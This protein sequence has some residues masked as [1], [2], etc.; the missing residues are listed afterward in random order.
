MQ[1]LTLS[2]IILQNLKRKPY[3]TLAV[4]LFVLIA[5][6]SLFAATL[7]L[8]GVQTSLEVGVARMG[9]DLIVVPRGQDV[10]AQEAFI[11]GQPT[12]F[13]MED[14]AQREIAALP[15]VL[16]ASPQV[17][18][19]SLANA[20]C[21]V[22]EFFLVSF[23]PRSDFT[24]A[25][26]LTTHLGREVRADE[27]IVGDRILLRPGETAIFFGTPFKV[28]GTLEP[29]GMGI[30]RTVFV[31]IEG[32]RRM[33]ADSSVLAEESLTISPTQISTVLVKVQSGVN[34]HD[35]AEAVENRLSRAQAI[36]T[37]QMIASVG[38]QM[39]S[40]LTIIL[41][42]IAALWLM[43]LVAIGLVFTLIVNERQR[44]L[45][46]LRAMG[47]RSDFVF[48]LMLGEATLLTGTGGAIGVV[49]SAILVISFQGLLEQRLKIPFLF[50]TLPEMLAL[51]AGLIV[52]ALLS[53][54]LA[55]FQ[56]AFRISR[57]EPYLAIRLGE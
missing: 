54:A 42:A 2:Y 51:S 28:V 24:I 8:R 3:R 10:S 11:V 47:A 36:T 55:C 7:L 41:A 50:P 33:I 48:R 22:G 56:P 19:K 4:A 21:C 40:L 30:D 38:R 49:I 57:M 46:L 14:Q 52:L 5:T 53:G 35:V 9:A 20:S 44:E 25:P 45:G 15:G 27:I 39:T 6:G 17:F 37:S 29:T 34:P 32:L 13:Y 26:W 43:A 23:D 12:T 1:K 18:V 31:P 16:R